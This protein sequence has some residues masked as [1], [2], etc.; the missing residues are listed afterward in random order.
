MLRLT[1]VSLRLAPFLVVVLLGLISPV[2]KGANAWAPPQ[3]VV[4]DTTRQIVEGRE[5]VKGYVTDVKDKYKPTTPEYAEGRKQYRV[6]LSKYNGWA[7]SVKRAIR[8]GKTKNLQN[9]AA[10]KAA[11]TQATAAAKSFVAYAES[12]TGGSKG[13]FG[14]LGGL[15]EAGIK[16]WNAVK[17]RK[18][19]ERNNDAEAFYED[20]KWD[21][22]ELLTSDD[23]KG[24]EAE[25]EEEEPTV[26]E[27]HMGD[28]PVGD[29][30]GLDERLIIDEATLA[31]IEKNVSGDAKG[32]AVDSRLLAM[33]T[34]KLAK[35][36]ADTRVSRKE[37]PSPS[38]VR[39]YLALFGLPFRYPNG[40]FVP[41][42]AAGVG[43]A[44][45][46]T[47]YRLARNLDPGDNLL[48]LREALVDVTRDYSKT[49]P[50]TRV[51]VSAA[52]SRQPYPNGK[53]YWVSHQQRP[54][55]GW[56]VFFNWSGSKRSPQHVGIVDSVDAS[57]RIL[58]TLEF[59]TSDGNPSN[60][61]RVQRRTRSVRYVMG[62]IRTYP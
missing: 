32:P 35:A 16:I 45:A 15:I 44:A 5:L 17:D 33:E 3:D 51:M 54:E 55:Q 60:G 47:H 62:Y 23:A 37:P 40:Q 4:G 12:K 24:R 20:V 7:A 57:G 34:L 41:Y 30:K 56:L 48:R 52:K 22:W 61:G 36:Y 28:P 9:D 27:I 49:H 11:A 1:S 14:I 26:E 38:K 29:A 21:Q 58:R 46:R 13:G 6:A 8:L 43:F 2:C 31:E 18:A 53:T 10:Y 59:N 39:A 19:L 50:A 42:C 25:D